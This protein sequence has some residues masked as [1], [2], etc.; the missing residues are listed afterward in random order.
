MN[1]YN[2]PSRYPPP[3]KMQQ[4]SAAETVV[5]IPPPPPMP[6]FD[7]NTNFPQR[8]LPLLNAPVPPVQ[9]KISFLK[10]K[11]P[12]PPPSPSGILGP[13]RTTNKL[14]KPVPPPKPVRKATVN[15]NSLLSSGVIPPPPRIIQADNKKNSPANLH[16]PLDNRISSSS[17]SISNSTISSSSICSCQQQTQTNPR[18]RFISNRK[19]R[20]KTT[21]NTYSPAAVMMDEIHSWR[22]SRRSSTGRSSTPGPGGRSN[23]INS[24]SNSRVHFHCSASEEESCCGE[25]QELNYDT[26]FELEPLPVKD[27]FLENNNSSPSNRAARCTKARAGLRSRMRALSSPAAVE[28]GDSSHY[29]SSSSTSSTST[30][31]SFLGALRRRSEE[32]KARKN[33]K[34]RDEEQKKKLGKNTNYYLHSIPRVKLPMMPKI[35]ADDQPQS[36]EEPQPP[37]RFVKRREGFATVRRGRSISRSALSLVALNQLHEADVGSGDEDEKDNKPHTEFPSSTHHHHRGFSEI[38]VSRQEEKET[39]QFHSLPL[40][41]NRTRGEAMM[42]DHHYI[43]SVPKNGQIIYKGHCRRPLIVQQQ[44]NN[45]NPN[46]NKKKDTHSP[47]STLSASSLSLDLESEY[48]LRSHGKY[49][50]VK[51]SKW[52]LFNPRPKSEEVT[53][54]GNGSSSNNNWD[55]CLGESLSSLENSGGGSSG[56]SKS[57]I[58]KFLQRNNKVDNNAN[59]QNSN[60]LKA[61]K[62]KSVFSSFYTGNGLLH[63]FWTPKQFEDV[64]LDLSSGQVKS[65]RDGKLLF[66]LDGIQ[67]REMKVQGR[68]PSSSRASRSKSLS[69]S[70]NIGLDFDIE[71]IHSRRT[72]HSQ[73]RASTGSP[74]A[75]AESWNSLLTDVLQQQQQ[76]QQVWNFHGVIAIIIYDEIYGT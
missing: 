11:A 33:N 32:R 43:K 75:S 24:R 60:P 31:S 8:Q 49:E 58:R 37:P 6:N 28:T 25:E 41:V 55:S 19:N 29:C 65:T 35:R 54:S 21:Q 53:T 44:H 27:K 5:N 62:K 67:S 59:V 1:G 14:P 12:L 15:N 72:S 20:R 2:H 47:S 73:H 10:Y 71:E 68:T 23:N 34:K 63:N 46:S 52:R 64:T 39:E 22:N 3:P 74:T 18:I 42:M 48:N 61:T 50:E 17:T 26:E 36:L 57:R 4:K 9:N 66:C 76:M 7:N 13:T 38:P 45:N 56:G 51:G 16:T 69:S 70:S 40:S 30:N